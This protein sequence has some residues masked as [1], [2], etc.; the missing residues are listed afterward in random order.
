[1]LFFFS[2]CLFPSILPHVSFLFLCSIFIFFRFSYCFL[3]ALFLSFCSPFCSSAPFTSSFFS[4]FFSVLQNL[5]VSGQ[6]PKISWNKTHF[7]KAFRN[8]II[9]IFSKI[10]VWSTRTF[11]GGSSPLRP[12]PHHILHCCTDEVRNYRCSFCHFCNNLVRG[13]CSQ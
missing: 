3:S 1:M 8:Y 12:S 10:T 5:L 6:G 13:H 4:C 2:S 9:C 7:S 11:Q